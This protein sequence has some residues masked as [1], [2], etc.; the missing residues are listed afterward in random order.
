MKDWKKNIYFIL[1]EPK[2]PGNI[3]A[4]ARAMKNMGFQNLCLVK[5]PRFRTDEAVTFAHNAVEI[6]ESASVFSSVKDAVKDKQLVAGTSRRRGRRR[7]VYAPV[8][9]GTSR[10]S[11]IAAGN[12][13][14]VLFGRE[15]RGLYNEEID[16]CGF[17]MTIP[18]NKEHPSL[19]LAQA[20]M[21]IAY[22]LSKAGLN[23]A[24]RK[25]SGVSAP[26]VIANPPKLA[27]QEELL[28]LYDRIEKAFKLLE[29][30]P[31]ENEFL[32]TRIMQNLKH[33]L[34]RAGLTEWELN[35]FH[36]LCKQIENKMIKHNSK[37]G[38]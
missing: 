32:E 38:P 4:S 28:R 35:M 7:G 19:N 12:K 14:A 20:V 24:G 37:E 8:E 10:L 3:G 15:D 9:Q 25:N 13:V 16:E 22:E 17:L 5:P 27:G 1:V 6:L 18:A 29:Y 31:P 11:E 2:E 34:G 30:I 26:L 23:G 36:G 21:V 33:C